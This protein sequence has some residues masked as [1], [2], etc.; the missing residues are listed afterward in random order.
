MR[1]CVS[2]LSTNGP[3]CL[4]S[5]VIKWVTSDVYIFHEYF[6]AESYIPCIYGFRA[7]VS[8]HMNI[9]T[10][11]LYKQHECVSFGRV[12]SHFHKSLDRAT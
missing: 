2:I 10:G 11:F 4:S 9:Y 12:Y 5:I 3:G 1:F 6:C 7:V 8:S